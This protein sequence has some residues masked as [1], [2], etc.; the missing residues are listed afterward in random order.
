ML[1]T[2]ETETPG[3]VH[4]NAPDFASE[5]G[6]R[7]KTLFDRAGELAESEAR[8]PLQVTAE[9]EGKFTDFAKQAKAAAKA[10][11]TAHEAEKAPFLE[12]GRIVDGL[13]KPSAA[14]LVLL[15]K[16]IE[17]KLTLFLQQKAA[18]EKLAREEEAKRQREESDRLAREAAAKEEAGLA[19]SAA[20]TF[21]AA[22]VQAASAAKVEASAQAKPS[23]LAQVRGSL[24]SV[25]SLRESWKGAVQDRAT[26]DLEALRPFLDADALQ[27]AVNAWVKQNC[28]T[29]G[30]KTQAE[31]PTLKGAKIELSSSAIVR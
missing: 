1:D 3:I 9:N 26:L 28:I 31:A 27:K 30:I 25:G 22:Q 19:E 10:L 7:H 14:A 17:A 20:S 11:D 21:V 4:N 5:L 16:R 13:F 23:A 24:G 18:A 15:A 8:M 6:E 29:A 2:V 12:N